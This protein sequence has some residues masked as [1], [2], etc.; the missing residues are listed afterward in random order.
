MCM[1]QFIHSLFVD[2]SPELREQRRRVFLRPICL[3]G[4]LV[5]A[6]FIVSYEVLIG[7]MLTLKSHG[8]H[9]LLALLLGLLGVLFFG[10]SRWAFRIIPALLFLLA[11]NNVHG[12]YVH[13]VVFAP[14][15]VVFLIALTFTFSRLQ[16]LVVLAL[17]I[18]GLAISFAAR[19]VP[20]EWSVFL[21]L[22]TIM[23]GIWWLVDTLL[24]CERS[25]HAHIEACRRF[26][27]FGLVI[28]STMLLEPLISNST[29][30]SQYTL[31]NVLK[32]ATLI[33]MY[34]WSWRAPT[35]FRGVSAVL[36]LLLVAL[37]FIVVGFNERSPLF[38]LF[39]VVF[40]FVFCKPRRATLYSVISLL[41]LFAA[42]SAWILGEGF[43]FIWRF[44]AAICSVI[45]MLGYV[46][47]TLGREE[48]ALIE[49]DSWAG[50]WGYS[51]EE[52]RRVLQQLSRDIAWGVLVV[53]FL[54]VGVWMHEQRV[55]Y[56][57]SVEQQPLDS[58]RVQA[59]NSSLQTTSLLLADIQRQGDA[60]T[61]VALSNWVEEQRQHHKDW[62][63][64]RIIDKHG[65]V[66]H[67]WSDNVASEQVHFDSYLGLK[68]I[69]SQF[70][71]PKHSLWLSPWMRPLPISD[72]IQFE[73]HIS[74]VS[75]H[76]DDWLV[77]DLHFDFLADALA[78]PMTPSDVSRGQFIEAMSL[79]RSSILRA[80]DMADAIPTMDQDNLLTPALK[81]MVWLWSMMV[82]FLLMLLLASRAHI[83][84]FEWVL[85]AS[86]KRANALRQEAE[87]NKRRAQQ[88]NAVKSRFLSNVSRNMRAPLNSVFGAITLLEQPQHQTS[89]KL[90]SALPII[91]HSAQRLLHMVV[92]VLDLS[93][94]LNT[95]DAITLAT[96]RLNTLVE[97]LIEKYS[98]MAQARGLSFSVGSLGSATV[99]VSADRERL[100]KILD[101]VFIEAISQS[102]KGLVSI[103]VRYANHSA[104]LAIS[105]SHWVMSGSYP[106]E[107]PERR[108]LLEQ[109]LALID[110]SD[111]LSLSV[112]RAF[113][114]TMGGNL[115][116]SSNTDSGTT[117][118]LELPMGETQALSEMGCS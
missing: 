112:C 37:N 41:I 1:R 113:M 94:L 18:L 98:A 71:I 26:I 12:V 54:F 13:G 56:Q 82:I 52:Y 107:G 81:R 111:Q 20:G 118:C 10:S 74:L 16:S 105:A 89:A 67:H 34:G 46:T 65:N 61:L 28:A 17:Y 80:Q 114:L 8:L 69:F 106:Q 115:T 38:L 84:R 102:S 91:Q 50:I 19:N 76:V 42:N 2:P 62:M 31:I 45:G 100:K 7:P 108:D 68:K 25:D 6:L 24:S 85:A 51:K 93:K 96:F 78:Q 99:E 110:N 58:L 72:N 101:M 32:V 109:D 11:A 49:G 27:L 55:R 14:Y 77:I 5:F 63:G 64:V 95:T 90:D 43:L 70:V 66:L 40:W 29:L 9:N 22:A 21:A 33:A 53:C 86:V 60:L 92:S 15:A 75:A 30:A 48:P 97:P 73:P 59:I 103:G 88:A 23:V 36:V 116:V 79:G 44:L 57:P 83:S 4:V 47:T 117:I 35:L 87:H 104:R 39:A 3:V